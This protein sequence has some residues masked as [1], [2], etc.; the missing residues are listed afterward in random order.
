A[1]APSRQAM[2][3][4]MPTLRI[5]DIDIAYD[6]AGE[7]EP[8]LL[9]HGLRS[10][11][12]HWAAQ[13]EALSR[14]DPVITPDLRAQGGHSKPPVPHTMAGLAADVGAL[15]RALDAGP[16]HLIGLSLGGMIGFQLAADAPALVRSLVIVN[17]GPEV[18]PRTFAEKR[19]MWTRRLILQ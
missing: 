10:S 2:T 5:N 14:A 6:I 1:L 3:F 17:S 16:V 12:E 15:I 13:E 9:V 7:G 19:S 18:I 11:T 4:V 8:V